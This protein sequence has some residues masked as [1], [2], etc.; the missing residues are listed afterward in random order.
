MVSFHPLALL[1]RH[2]ILQCANTGANNDCSLAQRTCNNNILSPLSGPWDVYYVLDRDPSPYPADF[3][4]WLNGQR[5]KIGAAK[6]W[7]ASSSAIY[8]NFFSTGSCD[9]HVHPI[10][11]AN[12]SRG[13]R[14]LDEVQ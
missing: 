6:A 13:D 2:Q 12:M 1:T 9:H 3:A 5:T 7:S 10:P 11:H 8:S 4:N 14:R